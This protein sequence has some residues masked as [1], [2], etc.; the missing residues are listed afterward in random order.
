MSPGSDSAVRPACSTSRD[1]LVGVAL[2]LRQVDDRDVGA[3]AGEGERDRPADAGVAA[4]DERPPALEPAGAAVGRLAV[5]GG[6][7]ELRLEARVRHLLGAGLG[8]RPAGVLGVNWSLTRVSWGRC[9]RR[10]A[11][12]SGVTETGRNRVGLDPGR[13]R[14]RHPADP[15]RTCQ[16]DGCAGRPWSC[17]RR[18]PSPCSASA[19]GRAPGCWGTTTATGAPQRRSHVPG[20]P[21]RCRELA[22]RHRRPDAAPDDRP[23]EVAVVSVRRDGDRATAVLDVRWLLGD[24]WAYRTELPLR[25]TETRGSPSSD[26]PSPTPTSPRARPCAPGWCRRRGRRSPTARAR[27][28]CRTGRS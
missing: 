8:G 3:L 4:G 23:A 12:R 21:A 1:R 24:E 19:A 2:L 6:R 26:R 7:L 20:S 9:G 28:S 14:A 10:A 15:V 17:P 13:R 16:G 5:V 18:E 27:R 11:A 22:R 25:R